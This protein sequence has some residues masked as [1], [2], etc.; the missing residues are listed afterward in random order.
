MNAKNF[1][2]KITKRKQCNRETK[3]I[4]IRSLDLLSL[5]D[6]AS[7]MKQKNPELDIYNSGFRD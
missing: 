1:L 7:L 4:Q 5:K 3:I 6:L 2:R